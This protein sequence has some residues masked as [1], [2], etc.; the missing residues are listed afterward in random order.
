MPAYHRFHPIEIQTLALF[1]SFIPCVAAIFLA[2]TARHLEALRRQSTPVTRDSRP[3]F[4]N[5]LVRTD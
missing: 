3:V 5:R 1:L 4:T 2:F